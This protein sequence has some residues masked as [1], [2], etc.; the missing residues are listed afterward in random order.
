MNILLIKL[1]S[2]QEF[3]NLK[4]EKYLMHNQEDGN[5]SIKDWLKEKNIF[6]GIRGFAKNEKR[7]L[8]ASLHGMEFT[9]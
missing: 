2:C 5:D 4:N 9:T 8:L 6:A 3:E 7:L 1:R